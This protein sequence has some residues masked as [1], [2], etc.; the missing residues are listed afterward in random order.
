MAIT[1]IWVMAIAQIINDIHDPLISSDLVEAV[2]SNQFRQHFPTYYIK[3]EGEIDVAYV[4]DGVFWPIE[5]KWRN[6]LRPKD[7][8]QI[9]KYERSKIYSKILEPSKINGIPILPLPLALIQ[10]PNK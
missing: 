7:V 5:I 6:Q 9:S 4:R 10:E 8:K 2:V 3:A 1:Q